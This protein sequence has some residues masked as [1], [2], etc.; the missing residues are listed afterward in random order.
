MNKGIHSRGYLPHWDLCKSLQAVTFRLADSVPA[1]VISQWKVELAY[2]TD[3]A[4]REQELHRRIAK[5]EDSG[6][7]DAVLRDPEIAAVVQAK[8]VERHPA[9][10][11][12]IEWC[13]MPTH[14]HVLFKLAER[15]SLGEVVR[16]WKGGSATE[17]NRK[18][19]RS[20]RLWMM[21]YY[22]RLIRDQQHLD[23]C[24]IYIR[25]NPVK[26][27]LCEHPEDWPFSSAGTGWA[28]TLTERGL[29]SA[30]NPAEEKSDNRE[31]DL[32]N[33]HAAD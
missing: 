27:G 8:L 1:S 22:D 29:Q 17:I 4:S 31:A 18:L 28:A 16:A 30:A 12:L 5:F 32:P 9:H 10:Y 25:N 11:R 21:D 24:R 13:I 15:Q 7:G 2:E 26:A 14:V 33:R 20:G 19:N 23:N 3:K 6:Q